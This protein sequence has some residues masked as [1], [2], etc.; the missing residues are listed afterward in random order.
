MEQDR[1][2]KNNVDDG[3]QRTLRRIQDLTMPSYI[4]EKDSMISHFENISSIYLFILQCPT[5]KTQI[6]S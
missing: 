3:G 2:L 6:K 5:G 4:A 1:F